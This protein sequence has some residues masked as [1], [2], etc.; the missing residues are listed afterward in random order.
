MPL[1]GFGFPFWPAKAV[2]LASLWQLSDDRIFV[3]PLWQHTSK[4]LTGYMTI[5]FV[6]RHYSIQSP[7]AERDEEEGEEEESIMRIPKAKAE[8]GISGPPF[9]FF[10]SFLSLF[11]SFHST[12]ISSF[13]KPFQIGG[14]RHFFLPLYVCMQNKCWHVFPFRLQN[15]S[16][17]SSSFLLI[18]IINLIMREEWFRFPSPWFGYKICT[19]HL[20]VCMTR[21]WHLLHS[22]RFGGLEHLFIPDIASSASIRTWLI[23]FLPSC[24]SSALHNEHFPIFFVSLFSRKSAVAITAGKIPIASL[25]LLLVGYRLSMGSVRPSR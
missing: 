1:E 18:F 10:L 6:P 12:N 13:L 4:P 5:F 21:L 16:P 11:G 14:I 8:T 9:S 20:R 22:S 19:H 3:R 7:F 24:G 2:T 15:I 23:G 17:A 25:P